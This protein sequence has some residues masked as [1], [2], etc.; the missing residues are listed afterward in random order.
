MDRW[1]DR[2]TVA[3]PMDRRK[4]EAFVPKKSLSKVWG[5]R[6]KV[7]KPSENAKMGIRSKVSTNLGFHSQGVVWNS[8]FYNYTIFHPF[9]KEWRSKWV[10][11][12]SYTPGG[13]FFSKFHENR[14][15]ACLRFL[16]SFFGFGDVEVT[17]ILQIWKNTHQNHA[18][19]MN[20]T[21]ACMFFFP[22]D[23]MTQKNS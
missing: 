12:C 1:T 18:Q 23:V 17:K 15:G 2:Q 16:P 8:R 6:I 14:E 7:S 11:L 21:G 3:Q 13:Q 4:H 10:Y 20:F 22:Y 19:D 5:I 9:R